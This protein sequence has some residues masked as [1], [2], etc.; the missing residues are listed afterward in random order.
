MYAVKHIESGKVGTVVTY[1]STI[2]SPEEKAVHKRGNLLVEDMITGNYFEARKESLKE[3]SVE[4]SEKYL[5]DAYKQAKEKAPKKF[6][7]GSL[8]VVPV[9]DGYACYEVVK[10]NKVTCEIE[11]RGYGGLDRYRDYVLK[12]G[13][14]FQKE[15]IKPMVIRLLY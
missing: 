9:A 8:F 1:F 11:W 6:G 15:V 3:I 2:A 5:K 7:V 13:G 14:V 12:G 10:I 4:E